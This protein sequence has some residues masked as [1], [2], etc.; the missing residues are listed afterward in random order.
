MLDAGNHLTPSQAVYVGRQVAAALSYA[1]TR[2]LVHRDIKPANLLFDEH[3]IVR[4]A[5]FGLARAIAEAS[6]TEPA[7]TVVGTTRYGAPEQATGASLDSRADLYALGLVLVESVTGKVP[8]LADSPM[9]TLTR[10]A[11]QPVTAPAELGALGSVVERAGRPD[12]DERYPDA[13]TMGDALADAARRLPPPG[14]LILAGV[15]NATDDP[16]PTRL[17][18]SGKLFDQDDPTMMVEPISDEAMEALLVDDTRRSRR[19]GRAVPF[20]VAAIVVGIVVAAAVLV[21]RSAGGATIATPQFVGFDETQATAAAEQAGVRL[22]FERRSSDDPAGFVIGQEPVAGSW[23]SER[24][25]VRLVL[26]DGPRPVPI[27]D[28]AGQPEADAFAA[29]EAEGFVVVTERQFDD[30][31]ETGLAI[32]TVPEFGNQQAPD[33]SLTLVVSDGPT[34][35]AVPDVSGDRYEEAAG[36]LES[37]GFTPSRQDE[38]SATVEKD[39]VIRTDPAGGASVVR[40]SRVTVFVS[41]GPELVEVPSFR[42]NT[43]E[44]AQQRLAALGLVGDFQNYLPGRKVRAQDPD[45]G[46]DVPK[47]SRVTLVFIG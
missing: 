24:G 33:T 12:P 25:T 41:K 9:G 30:E 17:G 31:V 15:G 35:V 38:F 27:P 19:S 26:S 4:V 13:A 6:W 47:G 16:H 46:A 32:G 3:A 43:L 40:G 10:R 39:L 42:D 29:L 44:Q 2:G 7:G 23:I 14:S 5:D 34:P 18:A 21:A 37:R 45:A 36:Q 28:V 11:Q 20:V 1:H 8:Q 22:E